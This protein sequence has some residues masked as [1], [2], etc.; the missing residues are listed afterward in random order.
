MA[1]RDA[2]RITVSPFVRGYRQPLTAGYR[3]SLAPLVEKLL[4]AGR[5][6]P[7]H[8]FDECRVLT[9]EAEQLLEDPRLVRVDPT[10]ESVVNVNVPE[11]YDEARARPAPAVTVELYG[12]LARQHSESRP[13]R[14]LCATTLAGAAGQVGL[15]LDGH[16]LAA[17]NGDQIRGDGDFPVL[18]GD[19]VSFISADAGG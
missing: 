4:E 5:R 17:V 13:R 10:L 18:P 6:R 16:V 11:D 3:T 1:S 8:L 7:A 2:G 9:L 12:V 14:Q 15:E 19:V